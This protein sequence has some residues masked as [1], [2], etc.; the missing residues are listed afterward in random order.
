[1][2]FRGIG[3]DRVSPFLWSFTLLTEPASVHTSTVLE[4]KPGKPVAFINTHTHTHTHDT[5][6]KHMQIHVRGS[7]LSCCV[8]SAAQLVKTIIPPCE[9]R[10]DGILETARRVQTDVER[11]F[12]LV[13]QEWGNWNTLGSVVVL[14]S[15][16]IGPAA[17]GGVHATGSPRVGWQLSV[18]QSLPEVLDWFLDWTVLSYAVGFLILLSPWWDYLEYLHVRHTP[19]VSVI[20]L[21]SV[22]KS[23][24]FRL[25]KL[26]RS[27]KRR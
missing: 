26:S 4:K 22:R 14:S 8:R 25:N 9:E 16:P 7:S 2:L 18:S 1:M 21:Q 17:T 24:N 27:I 11:G 3:F 15:R 10:L 23:W 5:W 13:T 12:G 19:V 20:L 6:D